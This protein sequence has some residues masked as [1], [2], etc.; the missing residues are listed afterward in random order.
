MKR[1]TVVMVLLALGRICYGE[2]KAPP[3]TDRDLHA[4]P[5]AIGPWKISRA[6]IDGEPIGMKMWPIRAEYG[7]LVNRLSRLPPTP[8]ANLQCFAET[9]TTPLC[10]G[11]GE[12]VVKIGGAPACY[13][14]PADGDGAL[15]TWYDGKWSCVLSFPHSFFLAS[16]KKDEQTTV[17]KHATD[18][19]AAVRA[20]RDT[21]GAD[22]APHVAAIEAVRVRRGR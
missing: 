7:G 14:L 11:R 20:A 12:K 9:S 18:A 19:L 5:E 8:D 2:Q 16:A 21:G 22:Q 3:P 15:I 10:S 13:V 1:A 6:L 4:L 17:T